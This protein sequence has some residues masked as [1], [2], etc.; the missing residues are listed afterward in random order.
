MEEQARAALGEFPGLADLQWA[1]IGSVYNR[2]QLDRAWQLLDQF[3]PEITTPA[4]AALWLGQHV[5][6]G[7]SQ[8]D[9]GTALDLLDQWPDDENFEG[10]VL[11]AFLGAAAGGACRANPHRAELD[12][13]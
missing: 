10:Q 3:R 11:A 12:R 9:V 2:G 1:L 7:F 13:R 4:Q 8:R 5:R 6:R